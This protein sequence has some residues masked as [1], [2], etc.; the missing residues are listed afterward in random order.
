MIDFL[1]TLR[2]PNNLLHHN[3]D[4]LR[5]LHLRVRGIPII[6]YVITAVSCANYIYVY[7]CSGL[8]FV[9]WHCYHTG[10]LPSAMIAFS[11]M[12]TSEVAVIKLFYMV[13]YERSLQNLID[14]F[15]DCDSRTV[16]GSR[17]STNM[18][19]ALRNVKIRAIGYWMLL[20]VNGVLYVIQPI[21]TPGH[22]LSVDSYIIIGLQPMHKSPNF[23]IASTMTGVSVLFICF[24]V[25]NVS[26]FLI[27]I[28]GYI[29]AQM[30]SLSEEMTHLWAD[31]NNH[32]QKTM[33][34][35]SNFESVYLEYKVFNYVKETEIV[36]EY[37][38]KHLI[39]IIGRHAVNVSLLQGIEDA[40]RG[41]NAVGFLFLIVGLIAELLGGLKNTMLQVPFTLTQLGVDC[42]LG[43]KIMDANIRFERAVYDC[44]WEN[45]NQFNKKIVLVMLQNSQKTMTLTAGGMAT[46]SFGVFMNIIRSTYSAYNTLG[47]M[48]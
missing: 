30:L 1:N 43:Q 18:R 12:C 8:W 17:F 40:M 25:A 29:E 48:I 5:Q 20:N 35:L 6:C 23:E 38:K 19:K 28:I 45:F 13:F 16:K 27:L 2:Y 42:Y 32:C 15:L 11:L 33:Q 7:V 10:D 22:H 34:E 26:G 3:G 14:R 24:T 21:V 9:F 37:V 47:S 39:D 41:P 36:N 46:L 4:L 44:K 31:A